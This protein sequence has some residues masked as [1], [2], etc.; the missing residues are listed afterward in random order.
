LYVTTSA[1][2]GFYGMAIGSLIEEHRQPYAEL[3][4]EERYAWVGEVTRGEE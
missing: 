4:P 3:F 1:V 2:E